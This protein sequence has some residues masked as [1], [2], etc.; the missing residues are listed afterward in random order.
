MV[1]H[2]VDPPIA[3]VANA[4]GIKKSRPNQ[5]YNTSVSWKIS[6]KAVST[7]GLLTK[8]KCTIAKLR[9]VPNRLACCDVRADLPLHAQQACH[10]N[11]YCHSLCMVA[12]SCMVMSKVCMPLHAQMNQLSTNALFPVLPRTGQ[13]A[14]HS[15]ACG[16]LASLSQLVFK[17]LDLLLHMHLTYV[18]HSPSNKMMGLLSTAK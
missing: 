17:L 4:C 5:Y 14:T 11:K 15:A 1:E 12:R 10:R 7:M 2:E 16:A 8:D 3:Q 13:L 9:S 18:C 6:G